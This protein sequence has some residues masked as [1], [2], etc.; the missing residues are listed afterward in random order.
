VFRPRLALAWWGAVPSGPV[1]AA[2]LPLAPAVP[3]ASEEARFS[4]QAWPSH[5]APL[6]PQ[7]SPRGATPDRFSWRPKA[8]P[9]LSAPT[10]DI[11]IQEAAKESSM[12]PLRALVYAPV[13]LHYGIPAVAHPKLGQSDPL[14]IAPVRRVQVREAEA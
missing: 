3:P 14:P 9:A 8:P 4:P 6:S 10:P 12:L 1:A 7:S 2:R 13:E 5:E 11:S